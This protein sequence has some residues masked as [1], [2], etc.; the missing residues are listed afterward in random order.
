MAKSDVSPQLDHAGERLQRVLASRGVASRRQAEELIR[1]G[2][3]TV[4]GQLV[5][6]LGTRVL[7]DQ[8]A[9]RVDGKLI[10][11]Q[12]YRYLVLNKP[13]GYITS[14]QDER[15]RL[16]VMD[17]VPREPR[18]FPV[19]RLDRDTE[20]LLL[21]TN[22]GDLANRVMHP[23]YGLTKEYLVLT[24]RKPTDATMRRVRSGIVIDDKRVVPHAF[25]VVRETPEGI[26]L[27]IVLHEGMNRVVRRIM[28]AVDIP[29]IRLRR[30]RI[31][32]L[33]LAGIERGTSRD[34]TAGELASL[35]EA[36]HL[37]R[38]P[39]EV[40]STR[41]ESKQTNGMGKRKMR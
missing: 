33:S 39:I 35:R 1:A 24:P 14:V 27:S 22:D 25:R 28:D 13:S 19:G 31:G 5:T 12:P 41:L 38:T 4:N 18:I 6:Q 34:L 3:V 36:L 10:R 17:L 21:F 26:L 20:G 11:P 40:E 7:P 23:R 8:A 37:D 30:E 29:V 9:I 15:G 16:T 32:P 2:R